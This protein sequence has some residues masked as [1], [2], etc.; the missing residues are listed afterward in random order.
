[1]CIITIRQGGWS[2]TTKILTFAKD[3]CLK[4]EVKFPKQSGAFGGRPTINNYAGFSGC[5]N[6]VPYRAL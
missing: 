6:E 5:W 4:I 1:M 2:V 3:T